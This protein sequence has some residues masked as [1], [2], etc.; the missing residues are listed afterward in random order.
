MDAGG[1][2]R[3]PASDVGLAATQQCL[4]ME[5]SV[6]RTPARGLERVAACSGDE[7]RALRVL[8]TEP[9]VGPPPAAEDGAASGPRSG[10]RIARRASGNRSVGAAEGR[11]STQSVARRDVPDPSGIRVSVATQLISQV[12]PPSSENACSN[13]YESGATG[14]IVNRTRMALPFSASWS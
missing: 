7:R 8:R 2:R 1:P 14:A 13:R 9:D 11:Q 12:R 6:P 10:P 3:A 4:A 5:Q